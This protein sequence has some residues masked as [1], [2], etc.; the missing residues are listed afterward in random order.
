MD[1]TDLRTGH[2]LRRPTCSPTA[3]AR[4]AARLPTPSAPVRRL[5]HLT[6]EELDEIHAYATNH[7]DVLVLD[8]VPARAL[9][10]A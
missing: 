9:G 4:H 5:S 2:G 10:L 6:G 1:C 8:T 7:D 3:G